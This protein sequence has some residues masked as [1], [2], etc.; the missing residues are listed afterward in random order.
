[1]I[2]DI[3]A[4]NETKTVTEK[5]LEILRDHFPACFHNDEFDFERFKGYLS[6]NVAVNN[7]GYE[8]RFLGKNYAR[9]LASVDTTTVIVPDEE[10]NTKPENANSQNV[11]ISG[12]N[13]H[14]R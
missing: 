7:E 5:Q 9:F 6:N 14:V 11:Y 13:A 2:K 8:L 12:D 10:H 1:M 4:N 3:L